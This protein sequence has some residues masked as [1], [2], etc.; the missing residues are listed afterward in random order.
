MITL[1]ISFK[2]R[3]IM[4]PLFKTLIRPVLE[5]G[6]V[7]WCP[8]LK[9]HVLLIENVRRRFTKRIIGMKNLKYEDGLNSLNLPSMKFRRARGNMIET[10]KIVYELYDFSCSSSLFTLKLCFLAQEVTLTN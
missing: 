1:Y 10:Y 3:D 7:V 4:V 6:N 8:N 2:T 9:K 5:Y